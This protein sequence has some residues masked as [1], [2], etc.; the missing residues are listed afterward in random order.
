[1]KFLGSSLQNAPENVAPSIKAHF[2]G[3]RV[4][5]VTCVFWMIAQIDVLLGESPLSIRDEA[6]RSSIY[7]GAKMLC[8]YLKM[9]RKSLDENIEFRSPELGPVHFFGITARNWHEVAIRFG[10]QL[11]GVML[12][13]VDT[14]AAM[15]ASVDK[16][17]QAAML[18]QIEFQ[19][20]WPTIATAISRLPQPSELETFMVYLELEA[21]A[22]DLSRDHEPASQ[23]TKPKADLTE[24]E[25][26]ICEAS[27]K[28]RLP[29]NRSRKPL[30]THSIPIFATGCLKC[31]SEEFWP[32]EQA[33]SVT[34]CRRVSD[35][36][37]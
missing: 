37:Q 1:M 9:G 30:A 21:K 2:Y 33:E 32:R 34:V 25:N 16:E 18:D 27:A 10:E 13:A 20:Q 11:I 4:V 15:W 29:A 26:N 17:S 28:K 5:A 31:S 22:A 3:S 12:T 36:C 7:A 24:K 8:E 19:S 35:T 6:C 23:A 14:V